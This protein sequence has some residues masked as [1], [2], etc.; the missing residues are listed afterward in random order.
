MRM[1]TMETN[2]ER[3]LSYFRAAG[4]AAFLMLA[5]ALVWAMS[6]CA[7]MAQREGAGPQSGPGEEAQPAS[8]KAEAPVASKRFEEPGELDNLLDA[9]PI[10]MAAVKPASQAVTGGPGIAKAA[11]PASKGKGNFRLQVG[12]ES[13]V[14]A[15]QAKKQE[16]EKLL[17]GSVDVVF[18]AP[19]YKLRWGYFDSRQDAEDKMLELSDL[20]IQMFVVK[21]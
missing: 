15:A 17:G 8:T 11:E 3:A 2:L 21:Q 5:L 13:D 16:Y 18:D 14:D 12:A 6:G 9:K 19:Y 10:A 4:K 1:D 20:K 7:G